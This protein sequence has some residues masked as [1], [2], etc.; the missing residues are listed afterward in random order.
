M[1]H[2]MIWVG[3]GE[4]GPMYEDNGMPSGDIINRIGSFSGVMT[5]SNHKS[6]PDIA[7]PKGDIETAKIYGKRV[8]AVAA[9]F[10]L[11]S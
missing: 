7:P 4:M 8:A 2:A 11:N 5:Q 10:L 3:Q 9:K 1:Q 6:S